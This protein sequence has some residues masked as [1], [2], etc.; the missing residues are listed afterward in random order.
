M[1]ISFKFSVSLNRN[2]LIMYFPVYI[3]LVLLVGHLC[4][5]HEFE[6][7]IGSLIYNSIQSIE[8]RLNNLES[9]SQ[10]SQDGIQES[11]DI[12]HGLL[13]KSDENAKNNENSCKG[14]LIATEDRH[15]SDNSSYPNSCADNCNGIRCDIKVPQYSCEKFSVPCDDIHGGGWTVIQKREDGSEDFQRNW[16]DYKSGFGNVLGE[17]WIG[18]DK[19]HALTTT[20]GRQELL[21]ILEDYRGNTKYA[22]YD[23][24]EVG[25]ESERYKLKLGAYSGDVGDSLRYH[26]NGYFH[27]KDNDR[28]RNCV[29]DY[30]G[31]WWYKN[32]LRTNPNGLYYRSENATLPASGIYWKSFIDAE[33]SL[34]SIKMMIR[35][36]SY[37]TPL[38]QPA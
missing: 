7:E 22:L 29:R 34:K 33:H 21:I 2:V 30:K 31:G 14:P 9:K 3:V 38:Q 1:K 19:L 36:K 5:A 6:G 24:F 35:P 17:F 4:G 27:T 25:S 32:C 15:G 20:Q 37:V 12:L 13:Y 11:L 8:S 23:A 26:E 28:T 10:E 16:V 18:L